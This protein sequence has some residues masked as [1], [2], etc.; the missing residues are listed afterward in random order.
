MHLE[1]RQA[2]D[3]VQQAQSI[4]GDGCLVLMLLPFDAL[5]SFVTRAV[6]P[7]CIHTEL[8]YWRMGQLQ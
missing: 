7:P 6:T 3:P 5:A 1:G 2:E 8:F 4:G